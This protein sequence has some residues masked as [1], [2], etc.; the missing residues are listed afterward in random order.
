MLDRRPWSPLAMWCQPS[1]K[2]SSTCAVFSPPMN[3]IASLGPHHSPS[4]P[5]PA[6]HGTLTESALL[7][8]SVEARQ[9]LV[10]SPLR[11]SSQVAQVGQR[12]TVEL[13]AT[14]TSK[15]SG[16]G[17]VML[18]YPE[19][20]V[21]FMAL[22]TTGQATTV[23][24]PARTRVTSPG[25]AAN[26]RVSTLWSHWPVWTPGSAGRRYLLCRAYPKT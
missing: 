15:R 20:L 9:T 4:A 14:N 13:E 8:P 7:T 10:V 17:L 1:P 2:H 11:L 18:N 23:Q 5:P 3:S 24:L 21:S 25:C 16:H 6:R 22:H 12:L 26:H 19:H